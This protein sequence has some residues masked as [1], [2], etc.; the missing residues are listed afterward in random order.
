MTAPVM[1]RGFTVELAGRDIVRGE[2]ADQVI[3]GV[4]LLAVDQF[5]YVGGGE[6][7]RQH[8]HFCG[9]RCGWQCNGDIR[10]EARGHRSSS[11]SRHDKEFVGCVGECPGILDGWNRI[12]QCYKGF[13][14]QA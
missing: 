4:V 5:A 11:S 6:R 8:G 9:L 14:T 1:A 7:A 3:A 12:Q 2:A 13:D 10:A